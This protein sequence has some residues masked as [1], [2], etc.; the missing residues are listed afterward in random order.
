[1]NLKE[2]AARIGLSQTT[3]S[4]AMSGYPEVKAETRARVLEAAERLGYRPNISAQRLATGTTTVTNA[5]FL[6]LELNGLGRVGSSPLDVLRRNIP[7][8]SLLYENPTRRRLDEPTTSGP[9][10]TP[11]NGGASPYTADPAR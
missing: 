9:L 5:V 6:Q 2:F 1:M 4:R 3:V 8:Y 7:G 11:W 10:F